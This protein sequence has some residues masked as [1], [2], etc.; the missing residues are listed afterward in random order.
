MNADADE[1]IT[2]MFT[3]IIVIEVNLTVLS[4]V[5]EATEQ[6]ASWT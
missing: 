4:L 1:H 2:E 5:R 3:A 6:A